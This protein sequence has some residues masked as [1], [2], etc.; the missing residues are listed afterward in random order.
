MALQF[1]VHKVHALAGLE[2]IFQSSRQIIFGESLCC[3]C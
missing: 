1:V 3:L 2:R